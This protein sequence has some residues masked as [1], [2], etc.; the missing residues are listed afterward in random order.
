[1]FYEFVVSQIFAS[2]VVA[3]VICQIWKFIGKSFMTKR[4]DWYSLIATGGM[5]SSHAT[6]VCALAV[7]V[8]MVDGFLDSIFF[9]AAGF[10]IIVVRDAFGVRHTVDRLN[11]N[12]NEIIRKKKIVVVLLK[13]VNHFRVDTHFPNFQQRFPSNRTHLRNSLSRSMWHISGS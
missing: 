2:V 7:S 12:V 6:F 8:G 10:A 9:V 4:L 13:I 3:S 11:R 5:P 1:M